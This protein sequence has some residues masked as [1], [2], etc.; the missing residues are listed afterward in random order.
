MQNLINIYRAVQELGAISLKDLDLQKR[1]LINPS[2]GFVY[3]WLD[4]VK[5]NRYAKFDP[6]IP[7]GSRVIRIFHYMTTIGR[8]GA[9]Q[10]LV[11]KKHCYACQWLYNVACIH[12]QNLIKIYH[13][14]HFH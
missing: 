6:N 1:C 11:H 2:H 3:Q 13:Y 8:T 14:E 10:N 7:C 5:I 12:M 9:Q 4:N